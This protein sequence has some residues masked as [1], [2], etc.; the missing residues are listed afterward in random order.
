MDI[1]KQRRF[2]NAATGCF[3]L[4]AAGAVAWSLIG[5]GSSTPETF[6]PIEPNVR[7]Q[8]IDAKAI[9]QTNNLIESLSL[10][11]SLID[12][13]AV[14]PPTT[15]KPPKP[16]APVVQTPGLNMTLV[17]TIID[18]QQSLAIIADSSGKFD[19][20]GIGES[21]ELA[22]AGVLVETIDTEIVNLRFRGKVSTVKIDKK[23]SSASTPSKNN[24]RSRKKN[25]RGLQ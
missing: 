8:P 22:P 12:P 1:A 17:G 18:S 5:F 7:Q 19:V 6:K 24:N 23:S 3:A 16:A 25:R 4:G 10:R 11:R 21:L 14:A 15:P 13:P 9:A 2:M 20:K